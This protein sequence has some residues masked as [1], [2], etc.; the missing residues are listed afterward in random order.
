LG[1]PLVTFQVLCAPGNDLGEEYVRVNIYD[2]H[3]AI[4]TQRRS[5]VKTACIPQLKV[6]G[7]KACGVYDLADAEPT[8]FSVLVK[9]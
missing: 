9:L 8:G 4:F 7:R 3:D 2:G 6:C 5:K 1:K